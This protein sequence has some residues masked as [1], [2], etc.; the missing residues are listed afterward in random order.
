MCI[1]LYLA[2]FFT[3]Y[4]FILFPMSGR[5]INFWFNRGTWGQFVQLSFYSKYK[6]IADIRK[7]KIIL[8]HSK[9]ATDRMSFLQMY[10]HQTHTSLP[11]Q[12]LTLLLRRVR[13][14]LLN[15]VDTSNIHKIDVT[16][17]EHLCSHCTFKKITI[18]LKSL[19][20]VPPYPKHS[21]PL[22]ISNHLKFCVYHF[23]A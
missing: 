23:L 15:R 10:E 14:V 8:I 6:L 2:F 16:Y 20:G 12:I 21:L 3:L 4:Y 22:K 19:V 11:T 18:T 13:F 17:N 1:V 5:E 9:V 7:A